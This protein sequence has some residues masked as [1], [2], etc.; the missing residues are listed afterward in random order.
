MCGLKIPGSGCSSGSSAL[1]LYGPANGLKIAAWSLGP[2][3]ALGSIFSI[4]LI[5]NLIFARWLLKETITT[6]K[7]AS[8]L[9]ILAGAITCTIGAPT[10]VKVNFT[11]RDIVELFSL[12]AG[13]VAAL[14]SVMAAGLALIVV[15]EVRYPSR[16][17][18][19]AAKRTADPEEAAH[20]AAAPRRTPPAWIVPV[21]AI[22]FPGALGLDEASADLMIR[23]WSSMLGMCSREEGCA[24][25]ATVFWTTVVA[26]TILAFGGSLAL[27]PIVY[28]RFEVSVALPVEYGA[29]NFGAVAV[30]LGFYDEHL[31]M[32]SWQLAL[33]LVGC[34]LI[35]V[36]IGVGQIQCGRDVRAV[37]KNVISSAADVRIEPRSRALRRQ[38]R[39]QPRAHCGVR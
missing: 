23:A 28:K 4:L 29:V 16:L 1:C 8:S 7:V 21:L 10:G 34:A 15:V 35:L 22:V 26:W 33:Q 9:I 32:E 17:G 30:A 2:Q 31:Y 20:V 37:T 13:F 5:F 25:C 14:V 6:A 24:D 39:P 36:G 38:P 11:D 3:S 27:M 19:A 12:H 18:G